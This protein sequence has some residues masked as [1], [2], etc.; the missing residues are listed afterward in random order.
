[1]A[2]SVAPGVAAGGAVTGN[3]SF[4]KTAGAQLIAS[5]GCQTCH[6][7]GAGGGNIGSALLIGKGSAMFGTNTSALESWIADGANKS[8]GVMPAY[9]QQ[10][11]T[12]QQIQTIAEFVAALPTGKPP[13]Q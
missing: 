3:A 1:M 8:N 7:F 13:A 5:A 4:D 2:G 12:S 11:L 6:N 10:G 9:A